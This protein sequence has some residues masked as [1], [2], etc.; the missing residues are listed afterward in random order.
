MINIID[1]VQG[2]FMIFPNDALGIMLINT[3]EFEPHLFNVVKNILKEG[4]ICLDC[5]ANLG[6]HTVTMSKLVGKTGKVIA[7]EPQR[8]IYQ[9]LNGNVFMNGLRNVICIHAAI[10]N[11]NG[12]VQMDY[13]NYDVAGVNIGGTK[14]GNGGENVD[15]VKLD[16]IITDGVKF[17]KIDIQGSEV[18]LL[19]GAQQ[20]ILHSRPI[21]FI[22]VENEWLTYFGSNSEI[23]L[24]KLLN[25]NYILI[26]INTDYN[27]DHLAVPR[28][29]SH[30]IQDIIKD[31]GYPIDIIDGKQVKIKFD[32]GKWNNMLYGSFEVKQ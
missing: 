22:E 11:T 4:D 15:L 26:R 31:V 7:I 27:C 17:I 6:Y 25:L 9:Q 1:T 18:M 28:E 5:G 8:I 2:K 29:Y 14:I 19:D 10:G 12:T 21:M 16:D 13:V 32:K 3:K 30:K 23:L 24:N 20:L